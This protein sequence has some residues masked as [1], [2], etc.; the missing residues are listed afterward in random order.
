MAEEVLLTKTIACPACERKVPLLQ[1]N[2]RLFTVAS[3]ESDRHVTS[4]Q[5]LREVTEPVVPHYYTLWQCPKCLFAEFADTVDADKPGATGAAR[6]LFGD[7]SMEKMM[8]LDGLRELVPGGPMTQVGAI[9]THL[10]ALLI[11]SLPTSKSQVDHARRARIALRLGWLFRELDG[12]V[13]PAPPEPGKETGTMDALA[14]ATERL[15]RLTKEAEV[16]LGEIQRKGRARGLE[17]RLPEKSEANPYLALGELIEVRLKTLQ[18]EVAALQMA[19]LHD[20]QGRMEPAR[21]ETEDVLGPD[22]TQVVQSILPLWP[23]LPRTERQ[24][25]VLCLEDLEYSYQYEM[26]GANEEHGVAKVNLILDLLVRLGELERALDWTSQIAKF[27]ADGASDLNQR[28]HK[29]RANR[30]MKPH[31]E[32]V[33]NR[34]IAALDATR[35]KAG[36]SRREILDL[37]LERDRPRIDA[38]LQDTLQAPVDERL[39]ALADAGIHSAVLPLLTRE[40]AVKAVK[41]K[42]EPGRF[43]KWLNS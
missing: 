9:A 3:R 7:I 39:K 23:E 20:Q 26:G 34:K 43:K 15:D 22:M 1:A 36:E 33:I 29:G 14:E 35:Q 25:L 13:P 30:S 28:I 27:A 38:I 12:A 2:P 40:L 37:M 18:A 5:W 42:D 31:D 21:P 4:Y 8:I 11:S 19:V 16:V 24:C 17:L 32:T 6:T 41:A 10:A